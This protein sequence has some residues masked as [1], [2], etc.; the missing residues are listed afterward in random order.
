[1]TASPTLLAHPILSLS[2]S[3]F[4]LKSAGDGESRRGAQSKHGLKPSVVKHLLCARLCLTPRPS[5]E[6]ITECKPME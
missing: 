4:F 5:A 6:S 1:M 3:S 2:S